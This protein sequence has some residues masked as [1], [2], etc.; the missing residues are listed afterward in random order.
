ML[1]I[2]TSLYGGMNVTESC[3]NFGSSNTM[4]EFQQQ[5]SPTQ[6][7]TSQNYPYVKKHSGVLGTEI[8]T[9]KRAFFVEPL[10]GWI[11]ELTHWVVKLICL[12]L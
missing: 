3:L 5:N 9:L 11:V 6:V 8:A 12:S 4:L 10:G 7:I 2:V 1:L